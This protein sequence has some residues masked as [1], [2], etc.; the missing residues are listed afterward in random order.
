MH[1]QDSVSLAK[2][3]L[4]TQTTPPPFVFLEKQKVHAQDTIIMSQGS[5]G[6]ITP[7]K[8]SKLSRPKSRRD[9]NLKNSSDSESCSISLDCS[10]PNQFFENNTLTSQTTPPPFVFLEKLNVHAQDNFV[11]SQDSDDFLTPKR[12]SKLSRSN[13][14]RIQN[15]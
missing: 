1:T 12:T 11:M 10:T 9:Q 14:R 8:S 15:L 4:T 7:Q 3:S 6:F 2:N 13:N 5:E